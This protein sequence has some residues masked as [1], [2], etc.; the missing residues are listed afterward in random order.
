MS[1]GI[2]VIFGNGKTKNGPG[3]LIELDSNE[4][5]LAIDH[6]LHARGYVIRGPRTVMVD[7]QPIPG[8]VATVYVDPAG[9][10][11]IGDT[12]FHGRGPSG[13]R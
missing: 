5:A 9:S 4:I 1:D 2:G 11:L 6:W 8:R 3:V 7:D 10:V 12:R 13:D